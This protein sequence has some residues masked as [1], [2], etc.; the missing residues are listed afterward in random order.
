MRFFLGLLPM[1]FM[2]QRIM[3]FLKTGLFIQFY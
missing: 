2:K 1:A 3:L